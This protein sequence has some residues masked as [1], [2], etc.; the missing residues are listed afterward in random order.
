[1]F[2]A[3]AL[4]LGAP[5]AHAVGQRALPAFVAD[6]HVGYKFRTLFALP[7]N[8]AEAIESAGDE[9]AT[10][11]KKARVVCGLRQHHLNDPCSKIEY[12]SLRRKCSLVVEVTAACAAQRA[13]QEHSNFDATMLYLLPVESAEQKKAKREV[14]K[15]ARRLAQQ[16][17]EL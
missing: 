6:Q 5:A 8:L 15:E 13:K 17:E 14:A 16:P 3:L 9:L 1:M 10:L 2:V 4:L 11:E 7:A 12:R